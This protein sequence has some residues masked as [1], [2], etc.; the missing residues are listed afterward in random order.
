MKFELFKTFWG[1]NGGPHDAAPLVR[2][3][4]F[5]GIEAPVPA[6]AVEREAFAQ[7]IADE[8]LEFIAEITTAGSYVPER[9]ATPADHLRD[10]E[11][12][13]VWGKP[14]RPRFFNVMAGCDAWPAATQVDF[15]ARA[16]EIAAKHEVTC[17]FET[18]R[19]R[20]FFNPWIT[21]DVARAVP[22]LKLTCD[23]SHWVSVCERLLDGEWDTILELAPHAHHL[24]GRVG[25]P[26][27]PQVPH[28]AA[29][30][31]ADCLAS[32]Q[33]I[34]EALWSA[35]IDRGYTTT[36][37]TPEFGPDGYLHTLPFTNAPVADL[38]EINTWMGREERRHIAAFLAGREAR[39][40][41]QTESQTNLSAQTNS[42]TQSP[43][44][45]QHV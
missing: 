24:H 19:G 39:S 28:P 15:F 2:A 31:Y 9:S 42:P 44:E 13:I 20:S 30:E 10:F 6:G 36:T 27:G 35:Q 7:A 23:F 4:G 25:Y 21:R 12:K 37:M 17:S 14:L 43:T 18:H 5:D 33:R 11:E 16:V 41:L 8:R 29:P 34:W 40:G 22:D 26:Q 38:W 45:P 32:H 3:A 1:F